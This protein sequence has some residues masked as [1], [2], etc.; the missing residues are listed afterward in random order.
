MMLLVCTVWTQTCEH[1]GKKSVIVL[2][3]ID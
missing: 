1:I 2:I 3:D